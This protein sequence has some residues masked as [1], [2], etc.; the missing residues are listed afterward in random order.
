MFL[1]LD[2]NKTFSVSLPSLSQSY[3]SP[4]VMQVANHLLCLQLIFT[5]TA[6]SIL[7]LPTHSL[8]IL[9]FGLLF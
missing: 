9:D 8:L 2:A 4:K 7:Q 6:T 5:S 1:G 3:F